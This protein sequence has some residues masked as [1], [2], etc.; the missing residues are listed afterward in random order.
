MARDFYLRS[1]HKR[2]QHALATSRE[3]VVVCSPYLT[4]KT[5][6]TVIEAAP[7][8]RCAI[9]TRFSVEDFASGA[10]SLQVLDALLKNGYA[11]FEV[12]GL[13]AKILLASGH[14]AS[15]GSQNLTARGVRNR[16][17]TYCTQDAAEIAHIEQMLAPWLEN[18]T[19]ITEEMVDDAK[20][21]LPPIQKALRAVQRD[22]AAADKE[23][24]TAQAERLALREREAIRRAAESRARR[25]MANRARRAIDVQVSDGEVSREL[26][27]TFIR[28][29]A[30]W[31]SHSSG[32][33]VSGAGHARR[34]YGGP[35]DWKVDFGANSF[36]VGRA[37]K[38]CF[39][40]LRQ[41]IESW[42]A[43]TPRKASDVVRELRRDVNGAVAGYNGSELNGYYPL[44]GTDMMFGTT[45]I[46]VRFFVR[47]AIEF[48]PEEIAAP[49]RE[50]NESQVVV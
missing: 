18:A 16:E 21:L 9:Y 48:L 5:A 31:H 44:S 29:S 28:R 10:S 35:A 45:S 32:Q 17:A 15:I 40:T 3:R 26:A 2:W 43:G 47:V 23:I 1:V 41:Y 13:H 38:R 14:F 34:V 12:A 27:Q 4:P 20:R 24:R 8:E 33:I 7:P 19:Q 50:A 37:I 36:L 46:D 39:R 30:F 22:A 11:A 6:L 49:L 42:E 25:S